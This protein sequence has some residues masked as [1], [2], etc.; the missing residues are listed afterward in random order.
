MQ[1]RPPTESV[2]LVF[3]TF[4]GGNTYFVRNKSHF[5]SQRP[6]L[7]WRNAIFGL[8][9]RFS[10][11]VKVKQ[12]KNN[13]SQWKV[14]TRIEIKVWVDVC[15]QKKPIRH[16][17]IT[18]SHRFHNEW[19]EGLN[20]E[21]RLDKGETKSTYFIKNQESWC[22]SKDL[23]KP[24]GGSHGEPKMARTRHVRCMLLHWPWG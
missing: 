8:E 18:K 19:I 24:Q 14:L 9:V 20:P 16:R 3:R 10:V 12:Q 21:C 1:H 22:G 11:R 4:S 17:F 15:K 6:V 13:G 23:Q 2:D 5:G 7:I